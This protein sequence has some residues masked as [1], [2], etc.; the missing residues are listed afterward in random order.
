M[1]CSI[2]LFLCFSLGY[3]SAAKVDDVQ[4]LE[5]LHSLNLNLVKRGE[6]LHFRA[7]NKDFVLNLVPNNELFHSEVSFTYY[8]NGQVH[9]FEYDTSNFFTGEGL[10]DQEQSHFSLRID[11]EKNHLTGIIKAGN[12]S[13]GV[14]PAEHFYEEAKEFQ[15]VIYKAA[16]IKQQQS[17]S[18]GVVKHETRTP[19]TVQVEKRQT[20]DTCTVAMVADSRL[21]EF[22]GGSLIDTANN[23]VDVMAGSEVIFRKQSVAG[24]Q[25][26]TVTIY[27]DAATDPFRTASTAHNTFLDKLNS[28]KSTIQPS[29]KCVVHARTYYNFQG[30]LGYAQVGSICTTGG[31]A[32][33]T[34]AN[35][36]GRTSNMFTQINAVAHEIGHNF[37]ANHDSTSN[38]LMY[39]SLSDTTDPQFSTI[40]LQAI[41]QVIAARPTCLI[42]KSTA[43][44]GKCGN[45]VV[46]DG[47]QC[48]CGTQCSTNQF[49]TSTCQLKSGYQCDP[50]NGECCSASGQFMPKG[51]LCSPAPYP[52]V[53]AP[54]CSGTSAKCPNCYP[55]L[56]H[57]CDKYSNIAPCDY[58]P[59][60]AGCAFNGQT[61]CYPATAISGITQANLPDGTCCPGGTCRSGVCMAS[62]SILASQQQQ[63]VVGTTQQSQPLA[64]TTQ[65]SQQIAG[66]VQQQDVVTMPIMPLDNPADQ[67]DLKT[68]QS[69]KTPLVII[70]APAVGGG[71][72][73]CI[74]ISVI[75]AVVL[76]RRRKNEKAVDVEELKDVQF[77]DDAPMEMPTQPTQSTN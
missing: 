63:P 41:R 14:E 12:E 40:S 15:T 73:L 69:N 59:C 23:L 66:T 43:G 48:D 31:A 5:P 22:F 72:L 60:K 75:V 37:G 50:S 26:A 18:C 28:V 47:E 29:A 34:T 17:H 27:T 64:G 54:T 7:H 52:G 49:C 2:L 71:A 8:K 11:W 65:Q 46:D 1:K 57:P 56:T 61:Q 51:T 62:N 77:Y 33:I 21:F 16:D 13:F 39:P 25:L 10:V 44:I 4:Y 45:G 6:A 3:V 30:I 58:A 36:F 76:V 9:Q 32:G 19:L 67:N 42:A 38:N 53:S 55:G 35:S 24:F 74:V 20:R 68:N 70:L